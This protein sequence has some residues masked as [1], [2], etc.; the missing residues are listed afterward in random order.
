VSPKPRHTSHRYG[1]DLLC[2]YCSL[3]MS[4]KSEPCGGPVEISRAEIRVRLEA[5]RQDAVERR[6]RATAAHFSELARLKR[7]R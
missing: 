2:S 6:A 4:F 1:A 3:P 7:T 5:E